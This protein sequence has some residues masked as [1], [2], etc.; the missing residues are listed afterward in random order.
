MN[1]F[2]VPGL[3]SSRLWRTSVVHQRSL[4]L[5]GSKYELIWF[6]EIQTIEDPHF[7]RD[8]L[9]LNTTLSEGSQYEHVCTEDVGGLSGVSYLSYVDDLLD[10]SYP[11]GIPACTPVVESH[12][13]HDQKDDSI[14]QS[15]FHGLDKF[16]KGTLSTFFSKMSSSHALPGTL[17]TDIMATWIE[18]VENMGYVPR[19]LPLDWRIPADSQRWDI[20]QK[21]IEKVKSKGKEEKIVVVAHSLGGTYF[22]YFLNHYVTE[23][24]RKEHIDLFVPIAAPFQGSSAAAL[25]IMQHNTLT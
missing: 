7:V 5:L 12:Y 15:I 25:K 3:G 10:V 16:L 4:S 24:W 20:I 8:N 17:G 14:F 23:K 2:L 1:I 22:N 18:S 9:L 19:G 13:Y 6:N 21:V 11:N